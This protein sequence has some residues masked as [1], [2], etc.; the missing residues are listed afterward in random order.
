MA[1]FKVVKIT[2]SGAV[3]HVEVQLDYVKLRFQVSPDFATENWNIS[4]RHILT[5]ILLTMF[6]F[7][8]P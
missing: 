1:F 3:E 8:D 4:T 7:I 2:L 5:Q 6:L